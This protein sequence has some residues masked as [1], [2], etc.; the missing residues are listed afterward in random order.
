M[1]LNLLQSNWENLI[2]TPKLNNLLKKLLLIE[3]NEYAECQIM[4]LYNTE[5]VLA[6][7]VSPE[8]IETPLK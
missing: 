6:F 5:C 2:Y 3:I 4:L 8:E 1:D 7:G